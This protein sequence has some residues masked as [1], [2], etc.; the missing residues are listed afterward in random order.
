VDGVHTSEPQL[1]VDMSGQFQALATLQELLWMLGN[2]LN[3]IECNYRNSF[4]GKLVISMDEIDWP[5]SAHGNLWL[6]FLG[7]LCEK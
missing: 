2:K 5:P 3:H 7:I 6:Y 1:L 4:Q